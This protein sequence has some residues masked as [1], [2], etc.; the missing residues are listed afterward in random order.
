MMA[1]ESEI[2]PILKSLPNHP[3]IIAT[4]SHEDGNNAML[5][6]G[7]D[8]VCYKKDISQIKNIIESLFN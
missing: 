6:L 5:A 3:K 1:K 8:E 7:A 2:I 4:S